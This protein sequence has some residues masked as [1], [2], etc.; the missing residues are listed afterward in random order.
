MTCDNLVELEMINSRGMIIRASKEHHRELFWACQ[1]AGDGSFGVITSFTFRAHPIKEVAYYILKWNFADLAEVVRY[2]RQWAPHTDSRLTSLLNLPAPT[3]GDIVSTG[4]YIGSERELTALLAPVQ[5][6]IPPKSVTIRSATWIEA[7]RHFAG[8]PVKQVAFKNTSS[9]AYE[10]LSDAAIDNLIV[11]LSSA[12]KGSS[13]MVAMDAYGG[14]IGSLLPN[15]TAFVHREALFVLQYQAYWN[16]STDAVKNIRWVEQF[17][18]SMLP[19]TRGAYRDYS[20]GFI[21]DWLT[22]YFGNNLQRLK[23]VKRLYDP[24][25]LFNYEQSIRS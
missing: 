3:Q 11:K 14:A 8:R 12:P 20:D 21:E 24:E 5:N 6:V 23:L 4:V 19:Y 2:W 22:A 1:G 17:R 18:Q 10:P 16:Q 15:A 13:N 7:V 25:N 9:Y